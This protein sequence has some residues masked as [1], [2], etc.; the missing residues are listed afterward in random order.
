MVI[1]QKNPREIKVRFAPSPT[2]QPHIGNIRIAEYNYL[3]AKKNN[4]KF[5]LRLEDTDRERSKQEHEQAIKDVLNWLGI[6]YENEVWKQSERTSSYDKYAEKLIKE[7]KVYYCDCATVQDINEEEEDEEHKTNQKLSTCNCDEKNLSKG[8]LRFRVPKNVTLEFNDMVLG[9]VSIKS[10]TLENFVIRRSDG[11]Y[12]YNFAVV[13]DDIEMGISHVIRGNDHVYNTFK[14]I[15]IYNALEAEPPI[16]AHVSLIGGEDGKKLSKRLGT[17]NILAYKVEMGISP[18]AMFNY[19]AR[20][21]GGYGDKE[22][23]SKQEAIDLFDVTKLSK[24]Q[25][26][27]DLDKLIHLSGH[28]IAADPKKHFAE[29][30]NFLNKVNDGLHTSIENFLKINQMVSEF[31]KRSRTLK[32]LAESLA[33]VYKDLAISQE[34]IAHLD[35][36][37]I[38]S[39]IETLEEVPDYDP[40]MHNEYFKISGDQWNEENLHKIFKEKYGENLGEICKQIRLTL[41]NTNA[42]PSIFLVLAHLG[43]TDTLRKLKSALTLIK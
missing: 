10:D 3:F 26:S 23:L 18:D 13:I 4:G 22:I 29:L 43:K 14:Q 40:E 2:G 30:L 9:K 5:Y 42:S 35:A 37:L 33:F 24:A 1:A 17:G 39:I 7:Q 19:L 41:L 8:A 27:F 15:L 11:S 32:E 16:F 34:N 28:Y 21:S 20:L 6:N 36:K 38:K 12:T 25:A 31:A